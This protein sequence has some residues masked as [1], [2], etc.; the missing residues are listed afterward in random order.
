MTDAQ[1]LTTHGDH[2]TGAKTEALRPE[3][4]RLDDVETGLQ[5]AVGLNAYFVAQVI[6][7]QN[8]MGL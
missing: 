3:Q 4:S 1:K 8:L 7:A 5:T 6:G 2:R